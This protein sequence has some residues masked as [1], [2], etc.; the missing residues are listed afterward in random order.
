MERSL[1]NNI[2]LEIRLFTWKHH[3]FKLTFPNCLQID[4]LLSKLILCFEVKFYRAQGI[5]SENNSEGVFQNCT[6]V[7]RVNPR[8]VPPIVQKQKNR[9]PYLW[10]NGGVSWL[11]EKSNI[12]IK[13]R[14][15]ND[16]NS[17]SHWLALSALLIGWASWISLQASADFMTF[18]VL[19]LYS[20]L[21]QT[22]K[23]KEF[24]FLLYYIIFHIMFSLFRQVFFFA[25]YDK[26]PG[27]KL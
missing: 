21:G 5:R 11:L 9:V 27:S 13:E 17:K 4:S 19:C 2:N 25:T 15:W 18:I 23:L 14:N 16:I 24:D 10:T 22:F 7:W 3:L 12:F 26:E 1:G 20:L 6:N 8:K